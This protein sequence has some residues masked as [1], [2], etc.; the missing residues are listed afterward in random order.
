MYYNDTSHP[1]IKTDPDYI[2]I[3]AN[4]NNSTDALIY[5]EKYTT[6]TTKKRREKKE[7]LYFAFPFYKAT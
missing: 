5:I 2:S 6:S 3:L 1:S 7:K 4:S